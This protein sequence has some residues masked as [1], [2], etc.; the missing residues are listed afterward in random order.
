MAKIRLFGL[1]LVVTSMMLGMAALAT[2]TTTIRIG[3]TGIFGNMDNPG[4]AQYDTVDPF[5]TVDPV[6]SKEVHFVTVPVAY[7]LVAACCLGFILWFLP[8][9]MN[10]KKSAK[11]TSR[12]RQRRK[13]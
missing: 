12:R 5:E 13:R 2:Q 10:P 4:Y 1:V 6:S 9:V 11:F 7:P 3:D 8:E